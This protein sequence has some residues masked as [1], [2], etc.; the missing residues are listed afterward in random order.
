MCLW[1]WLYDLKKK[2][3]RKMTLFSLHHDSN[4]LRLVPPALWRDPGHCAGSWRGETERITHPGKNELLCGMRVLHTCT[5]RHP[6]THWAFLCAHEKINFK[7]QIVADGLSRPFLGLVC[8]V[9]GTSRSLP[10]H[11]DHWDSPYSSP[12]N[13]WRRTALGKV[14]TNSTLLSSRLCLSIIDELPIKAAHLGCH[15]SRLRQH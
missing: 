4:F 1:R 2:K 5:H 10:S 3:K 7:F 14:S 8:S 11:V 12:H 6:H 13:G 9:F 15:F